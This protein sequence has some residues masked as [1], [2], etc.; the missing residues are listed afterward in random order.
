MPAA[1]CETKRADEK[2]DRLISC[3]RPASADEKIDRSTAPLVSPPPPL[4]IPPTPAP[5][6][7]DDALQ[8]HEH[9]PIQTDVGSSSVGGRLLG[10][11]QSA[12]E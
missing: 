12:R 2:N 3:A 11:L 4:A 10:R 9:V 6:L 7:S 5:A 1:C 8:E